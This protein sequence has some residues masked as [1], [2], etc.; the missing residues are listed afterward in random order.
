MK[1]KLIIGNHF[2]DKRGVLTFNNNF[3]IQNVKRVYFIENS[4][5]DLIRGWQGHRI[6]QRWFSVV[7]GSFEITLIAVDNWEKPNSN[8]PKE[9]FII[10]SLNFQV[11]HIPSGYITSIQALDKNSKLMAMSDYSIGEIQDEYRYSSD[12]FNISSIK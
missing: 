1:P 6:E 7:L 11:L 9:K 3:D 8:L 10:N 2:S 12:Y 4:D 5:I